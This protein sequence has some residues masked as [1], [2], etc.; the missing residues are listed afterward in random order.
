MLN[1]IMTTRQPRSAVTERF[2]KSVANQP[3]EIKDMLRL[4]AVIQTDEELCFVPKIK[5]VKT[6]HTK[7]CSLSAAR[8]IG[9]KEI[10]EGE[11]GVIAFPD[12]DCWY[13][14]TVL[15]AALKNLERYDF[16]SSGC[17]D[18]IK[19]KGLGRNRT[20]GEICA[21]DETNIIL[22]PISVSIFYNFSSKDEIPRFDEKFGVGTEW[23]SG[24]ESDFLLQLLFCGKRGLYD[25]TD[26]VFHETEREKDLDPA[27]TYKY[28]VG[29][30]AMIVKSLVLRG[31]KKIYSEFKK[32]MTRS[33]LAVIY[34]LFRP[35]KRAVY[36]ARLK[37]FK[38]G[39]KEGRAFYGKLPDKENR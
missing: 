16:V 4:I 33:R 7:P 20:L 2:L 1:L 36:I 25:S 19:K 32:I 24:E 11:E 21:I 30:A 13:N 38:R 28:S 9:I 18:P 14:D 15:S 23:G 3:R 5:E 22:K 31:Q 8:N 26:V 39:L 12:D 10:P 34:Y 17:Y 27:V 35:E 37:G 6:V 29:F